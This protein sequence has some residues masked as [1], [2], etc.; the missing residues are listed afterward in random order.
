LLHRQLAFDHEP[1]ERVAAEYSR[2]TSKPIVIATPV[3]LRFES[4]ESSLPTNG[5]V[6][7][8]HDGHDSNPAA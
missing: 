6:R 2:H 1:L 4:A 8:A 5:C 7:R 3:L